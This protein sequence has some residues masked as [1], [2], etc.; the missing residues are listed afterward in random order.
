MARGAGDGEEVP[1]EM[2]ILG[3]GHIKN[4]ADRVSQATA[5][6]PEHAVELQVLVERLDHREDHP[7][8][9]Q[10][11]GQGKLRMPKLGHNFGYNSNQSSA[12]IRRKIAM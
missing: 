2:A 7:S 3:L 4:H 11:E 12:P 9:S 1:D 10:V 8:H 5:D 6:Q